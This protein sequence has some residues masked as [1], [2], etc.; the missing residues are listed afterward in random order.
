MVIFHSYVKLP[1]CFFWGWLMLINRDQLKVILPFC[2]ECECWLILGCLWNIELKITENHLAKYVP[3]NCQF[4]LNDH[5][6]SCWCLVPG[7]VW[8]LEWSSFGMFLVLSLD[9]EWFVMEPNQP[10]LI[11]LSPPMFYVREYGTV[12]LNQRLNYGLKKNALSR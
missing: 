1:D 2:L 6:C 7:L 3:F 11:T 9:V 12:P 4:W 5:S 10:N 8:H